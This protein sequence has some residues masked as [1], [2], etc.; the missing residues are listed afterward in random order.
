MLKQTIGCHKLSTKTRKSTTT[1]YTI[2]RFRTAYQKAFGFRNLQIL[3]VSLSMFL[4]MIFFF[5]NENSVET[6]DKMSKTKTAT[7]QLTL[8]FAASFSDMTPF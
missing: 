3:L 5:S 7:I 8:D 6:N 2:T 4:R 1:G